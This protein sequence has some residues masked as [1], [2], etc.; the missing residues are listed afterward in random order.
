[1]KTRIHNFQYVQI[2]DSEMVLIMSNQSILIIDDDP[3]MHE[4]LTRILKQDYSIYIAYSGSEGIEKAISIEP[5]LILLDLVMPEMNGIEVL[6]HLKKTVKDIPVIILTSYGSVDTAVQVMSLGAVDYIE[7]P[8]DILKLQQTIKSSIK[9]KISADDLKSH[10][11]IMGESPQIKKVWQMIEKFGPTDI[12][13]L[14]LGETGTG[15][16][17]TARAIHWFSKRSNGPFVAIDCFALPETLLESELFGYEKG[18]FTGA[19]IRKPGRLE[20]AN[21]GTV[22]LDEIG[23]LPLAYQPKFLRVLQE[24][25]YSPLGTNII[26]P[27]DVR[28]VSSTNINLK[29]AIEK[30]TFREELYYR[31]SGVTIELPPLREREGDIEI[32]A[33]YFMELDGKKN[34]KPDMEISDQAM[35]LLLSYRWPGNIREFENKILGAVISADKIILPEHLQIVKIPQLITTSEK[36]GKIKIKLDLTYDISRQINLKN[37]KKEI[38][39][40]IENQIIVAV[41]KRHSLKQLELAKFLGVDAKTIWN[42]RF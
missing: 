35:R 9:K 32:L 12:P 4:V 40:E 14:I 7:K 16:E 29:E 36:N 15:K 34:N 21:N 38:T 42:K 33:H 6:K 18:A 39:A 23:N 37:I 30:G 19:N 31:I 8:F 3:K 24:K 22:L 10:Y 20:W 28:F 25:Q 1:V 2:L 11:N 5:D 17:L 13:I 26:K 27:L 41:Q